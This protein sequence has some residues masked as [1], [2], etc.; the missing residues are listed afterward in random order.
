MLNIV[1]L[2]VIVTNGAL[3]GSAGIAFCWTQSVH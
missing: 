1:L 3:E 2:S